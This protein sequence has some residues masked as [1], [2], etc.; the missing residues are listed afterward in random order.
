MPKEGPQPVAI[1]G[2]QGSA[3]DRRDV[4]GEVR[5]IEGPGQHG[6]DTRMPDDVAVARRLDRRGPV[7]DEPAERV[8]VAKRTGVDVAARL[9]LRDQGLEGIRVTPAPAGPRP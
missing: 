7:M 5:G 9:E 2:G 1:A 8:I 3:F 4:L 6:R